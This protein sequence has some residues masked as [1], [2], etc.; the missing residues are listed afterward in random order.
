MSIR[1]ASFYCNGYI[2]VLYDIMTQTILYEPHGNRDPYNTMP[3]YSKIIDVPNIHCSFFELGSMYVVLQC[4]KW[5][6]VSIEAAQQN[7]DKT[8]FNY[9]K[10]YGCCVLKKCKGNLKNKIHALS[11]KPYSTMTQITCDDI[12]V[13][14]LQIAQRTMKKIYNQ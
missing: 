5:H 9:D 4:C 3:I 10:D 12:D 1:I 13:F 8:L 14:F 11:C 2:D 7:R 6:N